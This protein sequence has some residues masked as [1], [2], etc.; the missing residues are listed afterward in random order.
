MPSILI[1]EDEISVLLP[2]VSQL[3]SFGDII[4]ARSVEEAIKVISESRIDLAVIDLMLPHRAI[5]DYKAGFFLVEYLQERDKSTSVIILTIQ[6]NSDIISRVKEFPSVRYFFDKPWYS[7]E[8]KE[9]VDKCLS[10][11][12][13]GFELADVKNEINNV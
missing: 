4:T 3:D 13:A 5:M 9:A 7:S 6:N 8:L 10:G 12:A 1:V 2:L 11:L